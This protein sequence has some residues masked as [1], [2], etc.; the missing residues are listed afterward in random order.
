MTLR[1][2]LDL[3]KAHLHLHLEGGMRPSTLEELASVHGIEVPV[4]SGFGSFSV[5]ADMYLAACDVLRTPDD[6]ARL[7]D[8]VVHDAA[9]AGAVYIEPAIYLPHHNDRLGPDEAV[10]EIVLEALAAASERHGVGVGL[11]IAGDRIKDPD[12]AVRQAELAAKL[13]DGGVVSFGLANDEA[14]G[15]PELFTAAFDIARDAGLLSTPHA[16]E[17]AGPESVIGALDALGAD[18]IEHGVRA[19]EDPELIERL[20][21]SDICLDVCPSSNLLLAVVDRME[22]HPLPQL[23]DAGIACSINA[24]DPLLFGPGM[25]EEYQLCRDVLGLDDDAMATIARSSITHSGADPALK[26]RA[27]VG[28]DTWLAAE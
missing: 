28:V 13:A 16:G 4:V 1:D 10:A 25:L 17:L 5:F 15:P 2:L 26:E 23:L 8:E 18:R 24:D 9:L 27:L 12:D 6:M 11:M 14:I 19:V 3:P 7:V 20:A 21:D 22:D